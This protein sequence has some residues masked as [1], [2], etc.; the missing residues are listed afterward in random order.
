LTNLFVTNDE[1]LQSIHFKP[2]YLPDLV[3]IL[4]NIGVDSTKYHLNIRQV[5]KSSSSF[6]TY[7]YDNIHLS[8][9]QFQA[10]DP[11]VYDQILTKT[12][13]NLT[14]F[15]QNKVFCSFS[16]PWWEIL[17]NCADLCT[18]AGYISTSLR[19]YVTVQL[20]SSVIDTLIQVGRRGDATKLLKFV[21]RVNKNQ[22]SEELLLEYKENRRLEREHFEK[23]EIER[24]EREKE[25]EERRKKIEQDSIVTKA[26]KTQEFE[27]FADYSDSSCSDSEEMKE[28]W[29]RTPPPSPTSG[30]LS[31]AGMITIAPI[32]FNKMDELDLDGKTVQNDETNSEQTSL[33][34]NDTNDDDVDEKSQN[35]SSLSE[36][37][38]DYKPGSLLHFVANS[39]ESTLF[40]T[41]T[42]SGAQTFSASKFRLFHLL[43]E[44]TQDEYFWEI[45]WELSNY[46]YA[47]PQ[48]SLGKWLAVR[49]RNEEAYQCYQHAL[50][51]NGSD[52]Q[53]WYE[54]GVV[55]TRLGEYAKAIPC[56]SNALR[57]KPDISEGW[58]NLAACHIY[59]NNISSAYH[60]LSQCLRGNNSSWK[61]LENYL[62]CSLQLGYYNDVL[63][64]LS[65]ISHLKG[66]VDPLT[67][68]PIQ[69]TTSQSK[70]HV[71]A[72]YATWSEHLAEQVKVQ[73]DK[74]NNPDI[75]TVGPSLP[76]H[77]QN[78]Q[79]TTNH[80]SC[81][82]CTPILI[83]QYNPNQTKM[84]TL[85]YF[86]MV[87]K[88]HDTIQ[89]ILVNISHNESRESEMGGM[90]RGG[91]DDAGAGNSS[92]AQMDFDN[93]LRRDN[94]AQNDDDNAQ[95]IAEGDH[96]ELSD[97]E[98]AQQGKFLQLLSNT[99]KGQKCILYYLL[100]LST[101]AVSID[102]DVNML[103]HS[104]QYF[105]NCINILIKIL[106]ENAYHTNYTKHI[107]FIITHLKHIINSA[108]M[109]DE[110]I[111]KH[112][113]DY[114]SNP[115]TDD[116]RMGANNKELALLLKD[117]IVNGLQRDYNNNKANLSH[118]LPFIDEINTLGA[119]LKEL[120][121]QDDEFF[122]QHIQHNNANGSG[123][124]GGY[125]YDP[126][127]SFY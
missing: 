70:F 111:V 89:A 60:A 55:A 118:V 61:I 24:K 84:D 57:I 75:D 117:R 95:N 52:H 71:F 120:C 94:V 79:Q 64:S 62:Q 81:T 41:T 18:K 4:H 36:T 73:V 103:K 86:P 83:D 15:R 38:S 125:E 8:H 119:G 63:S 42:S 82:L 34:E 21:L 76:N 96:V 101:Q 9:H 99:A 109:L 65:H 113:R 43:G 92:A 59:L 25:D 6:L 72:L 66:K 13:R 58:N 77:L 126:Y 107:G 35:N 105:E 46:T 48:R 104:A 100:G 54:C 112:G 78:Q 91:G 19:C 67:L 27:F 124:S 56:F 88:F 49:K 106:V 110:H 3:N 87:K 5:T 2:D 47:P 7:L 98:L 123:E 1:N 50:K 17:R 23:L 68:L 45:A 26:K 10:Q 20:W 127:G 121:V 16:V 115:L 80:N 122:K 44:S 102:G 37:D 53:T 31:G 30:A 108:V 85:I 114:D 93:G 69:Y 29:E 116:D 39:M 97:D 51:L 40:T 11:V 32:L 12:I 28:D 90:I 74:Y 22:T 14:K 33:P